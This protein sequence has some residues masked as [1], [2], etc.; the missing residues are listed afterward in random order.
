MYGGACRAIS[1]FLVRHVISIDD[2]NVILCIHTYTAHLSDHPVFRQRLWPVGIDHEFRARAMC[3]RAA[4]DPEDGREA[5]ANPDLFEEA[6]FP[7]SFRLSRWTEIALSV[8]RVGGAHQ[9]SFSRDRRSLHSGSASLRDEGIFDARLQYHIRAAPRLVVVRRHLWP[10][11]TVS[12]ESSTSPGRT[13]NVSP[14]RVVN[15]S[16]PDSVITYC[17]SGIGANRP[18]N[19]PASP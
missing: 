12:S 6:L 4:D 3:L 15:S 13:T 14:S 5:H 10:V 16:V 17:A 7:S 18:M 9:N 11:P 2:E 1:A 19:A 8:V